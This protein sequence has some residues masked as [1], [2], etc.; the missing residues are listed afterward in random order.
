MRKKSVGPKALV[1]ALAGLLL[2]VGCGEER[3]PEAT[4]EAPPTKAAAPEPDETPPQEPAPAPPPEP[5]PT[6]AAPAL[7]AGQPDTDVMEAVRAAREAVLR[8]DQHGCIRALA[9]A[10]RTPMVVRLLIS[11]HQRAGNMDTAC[12]LAREHPHSQS[13]KQFA[14]ARCR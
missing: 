10:P 11:C 13:I 8:G 14:M 5:P 2:V 12:L 7:D 6:T 1:C 9:K 4:A 3:A